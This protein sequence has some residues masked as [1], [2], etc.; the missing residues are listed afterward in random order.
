MSAAR[1]GGL[2]RQGLL[3]GAALMALL[4][5]TIALAFVP[6][7]RLNGV[8]SY[9]IALAKAGLVALVF[10][11]L[12]RSPALVRLA[13]FAGVFWL[14]ALCLLTFTDYP[15]R[16]PIEQQQTRPGGQPADAPLLLRK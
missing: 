1:E 7:G 6:L 13:A 5:L 8:A 15:F 14:A 4:A 12:G 3:M 16:Q 9:G 11:K 2:W 10:M